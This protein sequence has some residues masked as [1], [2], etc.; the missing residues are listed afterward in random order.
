V[1]GNV[2]LTRKRSIETLPISSLN[3]T[4]DIKRNG[5]SNRQSSAIWRQRPQSRESRSPPLGH[6]PRP[7]ALWLQCWKFSEVWA[8]KARAIVWTVAM[9]YAGFILTGQGLGPFNSLSITESFLGALTAFLLAIMFTL[10]QRR[11]QR[12]A[13]ITYSI[14]QMFPNWDIQ[15]KSSLGSEAKALTQTVLDRS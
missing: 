9:G 4:E 1:A 7:R 3:P 5:N 2:K 13:L 10:R 14:E 6:L 8:V 12:P 15:R 11:R